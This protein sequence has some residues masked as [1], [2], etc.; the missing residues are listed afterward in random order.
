MTVQCKRCMSRLL[1]LCSRLSEMADERVSHCEDEECLLLFGL[2]HD[3]AHRIQ[4]LAPDIHNLHGP[5][6]GSGKLNRK[7]KEKGDA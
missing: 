1:E 2:V 3:S 7:N 4:S 5:E 6:P